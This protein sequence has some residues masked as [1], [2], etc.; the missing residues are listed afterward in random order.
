MTLKPSERDTYRGPRASRGK[1]LPRGFTQVQKLS[2][3]R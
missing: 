2:S 1:K 3:Q